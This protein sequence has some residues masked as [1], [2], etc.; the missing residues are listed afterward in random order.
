MMLYLV[1][2]ISCFY[3]GR[4][5]DCGGNWIA[6]TIIVD[7][8]KKGSF[9]TIQAAIDSINNQNKNWVMINISPGIYK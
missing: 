1:L 4:A 3:L 9:V 7:Q 8:H 2:F 6:N 5:I